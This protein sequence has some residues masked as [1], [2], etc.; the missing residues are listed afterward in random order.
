LWELF[1]SLLSVVYLFGLWVSDEDW[2][3]FAG[4]EWVIW[5]RFLDLSQV[6]ES[7]CCSGDGTR[8]CWSF[9]K[10]KLYQY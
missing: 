10:Y 7:N 3:L 9:C 6:V 4:V 1:A 8:W 2:F 5:L